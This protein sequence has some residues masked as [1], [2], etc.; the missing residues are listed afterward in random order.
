MK[1]L[2]STK[3]NIGGLDAEIMIDRRNQ[4]QNWCERKLPVFVSSN[5]RNH[6]ISWL[7]SICFAIF[8]FTK[9]IAMLIQSISNISRVHGHS[10]TN[11]KIAIMFDLTRQH[12]PPAI[13]IEDLEDFFFHSHSH[14]LQPEINSVVVL[15]NLSKKSLEYNNRIFFYPSLGQLVFASKDGLLDKFWLLAKAFY[16]T[17][18][19]VRFCRNLLGQ[20]GILPDLFEVRIFLGSGLNTNTGKAFVTNT[21]FN[22]FPS[23]F[24]LDKASRFF[25]TE[26]LHYSENSLPLTC[27]EFEE[28]GT[29]HWIFNSRVDTHKV[30]TDEYAR[31]LASTNPSLSVDAVGSLIFR[32]I[33][34]KQICEINRNQILLLDVNPS[35]H[36][37]KNGPY[38]DLAG[39]RFLSCIED[40][41]PA[42]DRSYLPK[43]VF[44]IKSKRRRIGAHSDKYLNHKMGLIERSIVVEVPWQTNLYSLIAESAVVLCTVGTSPALIARE[45]GIPVAMFYSGENEL[46]SPLVDY[47]IPILKDSAEVYSFLSSH[48]ENL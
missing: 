48:L 19:S 27:K 34:V 32:P 20:I 7:V 29:P 47:G 13:P 40:I 23:I 5:P 43:P 45:L 28:K 36:E 24:Y 44:K 30:W 14:L 42:L 15:N 2:F 1:R 25:D 17:I 26:M 37:S 6:S 8:G 39:E 3:V 31:F 10:F 11:H 16:Q 4:F 33:N 22:S 35:T 12:L 9:F 41:Q 38:T 21:S 46:M 18:A